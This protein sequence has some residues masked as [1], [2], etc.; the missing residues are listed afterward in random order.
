MA[1]PVRLVVPLRWLSTSL[2]DF[3]RS[4]PKQGRSLDACKLPP[5]K[6]K[7]MFTHILKHLV[8]QR[9]G[10]S[11]AVALAP[12]VEPRQ[13]SDRKVVSED[14]RTLPDVPEQ[15]AAPPEPMLAAGTIEELAAIFAVRIRDIPDNGFH[16]LF[17][18][19]G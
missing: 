9:E 11:K 5:R 7:T 3:L 8:S 12:P 1:L 6:A 2:L 14:S 4:L 17:D 18:E 19:A 13:V 15:P 16:K 10:K